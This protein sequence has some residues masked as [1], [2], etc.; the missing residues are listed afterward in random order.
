[1]IEYDF[2]VLVTGHLTRL[3]TKEDVQVEIDFYAHVL[4][5][6][7]AAAETTPLADVIAGT[8]VF[9][10]GNANEGNIWCVVRAL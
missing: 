9:E 3:G 8:G 1:M 5:G 7:L 10:P 2:D 6:A 4:E